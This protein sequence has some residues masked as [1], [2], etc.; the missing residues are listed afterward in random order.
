MKRT[1][2]ILDATTNYC[3]F[4]AQAKT[5]RGAILVFRRS[6]LLEHNYH[7]VHAMEVL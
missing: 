5:E 2:A 3:V 7:F 6:Y 4:Y 1:F